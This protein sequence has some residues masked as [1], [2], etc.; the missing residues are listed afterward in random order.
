M[1]K[2]IILLSFVLS[3]CYSFAQTADAI[4]YSENGDKFS[5]Y[6]NGE[7]MNE[8]PQV[9]VK[10]KG[11]TSEFYQ[12]RI[13]FEN[14]A[15]G[16]FQSNMFAVKFGVE[17]TYRI[18]LTKNGYALRFFSERPITPTTMQIN[19]PEVVVYH[20]ALSEQEVVHTEIKGGH[21]ENNGVHIQTTTPAGQVNT[22][23]TTT[24]TTT[25]TNKNRPTGAK[26]NGGNETVNMNVNVG[27]VNMGV[28]MN[29]S[30]M[31]TEA[32]SGTTTTYS[33]TTT[34]TTTTQGNTAH[35]AEKHHPQE[36]SKP[37]PAAPPVQAEPQGPC[38]R[39]TDNTQFQSAKGSIASKSF[40]DS[41]MTLAKQITK[42]HC[43]TAMQIKEVMELFDFEADRLTYAKFAYDHCFDPANYYVVNDAFQF[44]S[45]IDELNTYIESK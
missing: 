12:T 2:S 24:T 42:S 41:K 30:G 31:E 38:G 40:S 44:E 8:T 22:S 15:L 7:L 1:K 28:N 11:L 9:N 10:L 19:D 4:V 39:M 13:D 6:L 16:D 27:G 36:A 26:N 33:Q 20:P 29:V 18:K 23:T 3:A 17:S 43:L 37:R 14:P 32:Q 5:I 35:Q 34:T 21:P 45:S 25:T